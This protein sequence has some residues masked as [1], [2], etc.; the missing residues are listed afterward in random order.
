MI[1]EKTLY[2][3]DDLTIIPEVVSEIRHRGEI[4][5]YHFVDEKNYLPIFVSPMECVINKNNFNIYEKNNVIPIL[6]RTES[7]EERYNYATSG[8]WAAFGLE[9]FKQLFIDN[10]E[11]NCFKHICV[12][13]DIANGDF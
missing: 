4:N 6:P 2:A 13:I 11:L 7:L 1:I 3:L 12:L 8:K 10:R 5:P 9:E